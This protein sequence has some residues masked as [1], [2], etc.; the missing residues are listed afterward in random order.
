MHWL[1]M[2]A[3]AR[4]LAQV[5]LDHHR[6]VCAPRRGTKPAIDSC[7]IAYGRLCE[8]AGVPH[9]T[10]SVGPFLWEVAEWCEENGWPPLNALAVNRETRMPGEGYDG[11]PGCTLFAWP[12][13]AR[14][15]IEFG[16]YPAEV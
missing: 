11:A 15:A 7:V 9:L 4:A 16:G 12:E 3:E 2:T 8:R 1:R 13:E 14:A 10:H 5:L 6:L